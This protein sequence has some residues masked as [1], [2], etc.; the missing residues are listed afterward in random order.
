MDGS[1]SLQC[2]SDGICTCKDH[3]AGNKCDHIQDGYF[4]LADPTGENSA[5]TL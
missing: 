2:N 4:N 3:V 5:S 1:L